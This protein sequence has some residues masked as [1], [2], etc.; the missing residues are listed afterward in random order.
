MVE[1]IATPARYSGKMVGHINDAV[2]IYICTQNI[3]VYTVSVQLFHAAPCKV[4]WVFFIP[5]LH[6]APCKVRWVAFVRSVRVLARVPVL[7]FLLGR[8]RP[9]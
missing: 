1:I 8:G 9:R 7:D 2:I 3:Q 5:L 4:R 6:I